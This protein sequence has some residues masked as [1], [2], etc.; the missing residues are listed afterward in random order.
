MKIIPALFIQNGKV[1]SLYKGKDNDQKRVYDKAPHSVAAW[2]NREGAKT[3]FVVDLEGKEQK[4]LPELKEHFKGEIWWA[5][6]VRD[7][8]T[9]NT[10]LQNGVSRVVLG[11]SAQLIYKEALELH[12]SEKIFVGLQ[13]FHYDDAPDFCEKMSGHGFKHIVIKDMNAQG[14]LFQPNFDVIEKCHYFSQ[15]KVYASGGIAK[16]QH[17]DLLK[18]AGASGVILA[19]ALYEGQL[20]LKALI[21]RY[22]RESS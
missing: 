21:H 10:L 5:G 13:S 22:E 9:L 6:K 4:R 19:R 16:T 8:K 11:A 18:Q 7:M 12:G 17:I 15:A 2:F 14:T 3:L 20:S 1:V